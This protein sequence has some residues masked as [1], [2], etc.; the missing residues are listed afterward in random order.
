MNEHDRAVS[1]THADRA[2]MAVDIA[3]FGD[4]S[5]TD[6]V[7]AHLRTSLYRIVSEAFTSSNVPWSECLR[8]DRG[9]GILILTPA[10]V[11]PS[12]LVGPV[13][14]HL[15]AEVRR[16][17]RVSSEAAQI[18]LRI[19]VHAGSVAVD[20]F[21]VTG[22]AVNHMFRLLDARPF[23]EAVRVSGRDVGLI[24]SDYFYDS[25]VRHG[26]G[27]Q[28]PADFTPVR[29]EVKETKA[30]AWVTIPGSSAASLRMIIP[31]DQGG[32]GGR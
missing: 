12:L 25:V 2:M 29:V 28:D 24:V 22:H 16:H 32:L 19:A 3:G 15:A 9:D 6:L 10:E 30:R 1:R 7:Q 26:L 17:N 23:K 14:L 4:P 5:R 27:T 11:D 13:L 8:E 31:Q 21:G 18:R 20:D